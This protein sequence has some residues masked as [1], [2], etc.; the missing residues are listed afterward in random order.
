MDWIWTDR[1]DITIEKLK[2]LSFFF[3]LFVLIKIFISQA[4]KK[5]KE[6]TK[7]H[8]LQG[9]VTPPVT[10]SN[11]NSTSL[12]MSG[13]L[14]RFL[15]W[16]R[17]AKEEVVLANNMDILAFICQASTLFCVS[18]ICWKSQLSFCFSLQSS[19]S[20]FLANRPQFPI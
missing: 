16:I 5:G 17:N 12:S 1:N 20:R 18:D 9:C 15:H 4:K 19:F 14:P 3:A 10:V 6:K 2:I 8:K 13:K 7:L 11:H